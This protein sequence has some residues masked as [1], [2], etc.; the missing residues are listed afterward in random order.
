MSFFRSPGR[1]E[2][3][4][5]KYQRR[6]RRLVLALTLAASLQTLAQTPLPRHIDLWLSDP[7]AD[8]QLEG[9]TDKTPR[10]WS[11]AQTGVLLQSSGD[12]PAQQFSLHHL[13]ADTNSTSATQRCFQWRVGEQVL[14]QG[15]V[16]PR[17]SS[18]RVAKPMLIL[19][20]DH[21]SRNTP[22]FELA[23]G[24]PDVLR[25]AVL[26]CAHGWK[27]FPLHEHH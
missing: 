26:Q 16:V 22:T 9:C 20:L 17:D 1:V 8:G 24:F 10:H 19:V 2:T 7:P 14:A 15:A 18:R 21:L 4:R 3:S 27:D 12:P 13:N 11:P 25:N 5:I 6:C 23:C